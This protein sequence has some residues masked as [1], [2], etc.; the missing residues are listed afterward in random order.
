MAPIKYNFSEKIFLEKIDSN[1]R[2]R[3]AG[4]IFSVNNYQKEHDN[5][6][7]QKHYI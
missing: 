5:H 1:F 6:I 4:V 3:N 7:S 2:Y